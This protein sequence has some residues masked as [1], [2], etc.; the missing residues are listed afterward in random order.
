MPRTR[1]PLILMLVS[2]A[3]LFTPGI[4]DIRWVG[5]MVLIYI[6]IPWY[7]VAL[8]DKVEHKLK[9]EQKPKNRF[10][11]YSFTLL[12]F[13]IISAVIGVAIDLFIMYQIYTDPTTTSISDG[14]TRLFVGTPF[15]GFGA[16]L[17]FLSMGQADNET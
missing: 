14:L 3:L 15:F 16:Y 12:I 2:I 11:V 4:G 1:N 8:K 6:G 17:I 7:I 9:F 10:R 5:L 13:G